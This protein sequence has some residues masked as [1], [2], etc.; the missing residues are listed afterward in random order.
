VI[1]CSI[2]YLAVVLSSDQ[3]QARDA[4][5]LRSVLGAHIYLHK[6]VRLREMILSTLQD[7]TRS[8]FFSFWV[9]EGRLTCR[10]SPS[11]HLPGLALYVRIAVVMILLDRLP[12]FQPHLGR[13]RGRLGRARE[14]AASG[15]DQA[16]PPPECDSLS[17]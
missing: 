13:R 3:V 16:L 4:S 12:F 1:L 10:P 15:P 8:F 7:S 17:G 2:A 14:S 11:S 5:P 9:W 6:F